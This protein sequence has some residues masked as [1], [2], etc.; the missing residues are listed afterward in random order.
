MEIG[1][2]LMGAI[3]LKEDPSTNNLGSRGR[4]GGLVI[5]CGALLQHV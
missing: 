2:V 3:G 5:C 1:K 4:L